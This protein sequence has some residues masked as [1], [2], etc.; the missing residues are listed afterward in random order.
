[1]LSKSGILRSIPLLSLCVTWAVHAQVDT[2]DRSVL[3]LPPAAYT[4]QLEPTTGDSTPQYP[5]PVTAPKNAP[6]ILLVMTDDVGF[7]AS[8]TFGGPIPT[9]NL[10]RLAANGLRYNRFHTTAICSPTR[11]SLL[12]GRNHHAVGAGTLSDFA[13]PYPGYTSRIPRSAATIARILRDNGYNTAMIGKDHN[14]P[15][16]ERSPAGPFDQWPTGRGFEYFY[17]FVAGD[18]D[19]Y[20]PSLVQGTSRLDGSH[21]DPGY[22][23]ERDLT[24]HA[25][26]WLHNQQA[27]APSKPFFLY[28][29]SPSAHAPHQAPAEWIAKFR[30][31]FDMGWDRER[32]QILASQKA[33]GIV[34]TDTHLTPRPAQIPAWDS[35][36]PDQQKVYARFMEVYAGMLAF[37]DAQFGRLMDELERMGLAGNTLVIFIEGDNGGSAEGGPEGSLNETAD[38]TAAPGEHEKYDVEW[39]A[40]HLD[41]LGGPDTYEVYQVGWAWATDTPFQWTKQIAS[42]LGGTRNGLVISW[43]HRI[44]Q[45]GGL[46]S[47]YHHVIDIMPT[48]LEAA[49]VPA[50]ETVDGV[51]QQPIDGMSML[52]SFNAPDTPSPRRTQYYEMLGNRGIYHD[53]WLANTAPRNMPWNI[54][55]VRGDSDV[56]T[57]P[58]ELYHLEDDFSQS[59]N[60]A[61]QQPDKLKEMQHIFDEEA[62]RNNVYPI[63]DSGAVYRMFKMMWGTKTGLRSDYV[64]WGPNISMTLLAAPPII[65]LPFT[66]EA[67]IEVPEGGGNGVIAAGGSKFGGWSFYLEDGKPVGYAAVSP[68]PGGQSKVTAN[69]SLSPGS[70]TVRYDF[71]YAGEGGNLT[72]SVDGRE[73]ASGTVAARPGILAGNGETFDI[74]RDTNTQ[75][76][77]DYEHGGAFD[78]KIEKVEVRMKMLDGA[79]FYLK[80]FLKDKIQEISEKLL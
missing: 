68:L 65:R 8:S 4:G 60:L 70:H 78:G 29:A 50:P 69:E 58:W 12:T 3:P 7:S 46:R 53:G 40:N 15:P 49:D 38:L 73:V 32:E 5:A 20:T 18:T 22:I 26:A 66:L 55:K 37:E 57:Y 79:G 59:V 13:S 51:E 56:T 25:I 19:Q 27:A 52:Y 34:P 61:A 44:A 67:N 47:Q 36:S 1:M 9:P 33:L 16:A 10:D 11:A 31:K 24:D 64:Y 76:S 35:L 45:P 30:G 42:H 28:Y 43:P 14:V 72:I 48:L 54:G 75:V 21:R 62:R 77:M 71:D 23:L 2:P 41:V 74:G 17:G 80:E 39:L 6:N 63:Q